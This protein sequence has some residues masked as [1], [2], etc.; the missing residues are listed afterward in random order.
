MKAAR[1]VP[2]SELLDKF[3]DAA[4]SIG[5]DL[6]D[7]DISWGSDKQLTL[8]EAS[9]VHDIIE[10]RITAVLEDLGERDQDEADKQL[11]KQAKSYLKVLDRLRAGA[12]QY[13]CMEE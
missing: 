5:E 13:Y 6:R 9:Y 10:E 11:R 12:T 1:Y 3:P 7:S 2:L 8:A 4:E